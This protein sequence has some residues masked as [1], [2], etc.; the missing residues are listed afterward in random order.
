M[1]IFSLFKAPITNTKPADSWTL[2]QAYRYIKSEDAR[3]QTE[4][5]RAMTEEKQKEEKPRRF[6]SATFSGTFSSRSAEGL[7]TDSGLICIDI[8]H[9]REHGWEPATLKELIAGDGN[10]ATA[11]AFV[12]PRGDGLKAVLV[13]PDGFAHDDYFRT[14][15]RYFHEAYGIDVDPSCRDV[16]R[17]CFLP[18]DAD[19]YFDEDPAAVEPGKLAQWRM[20]FGAPSAGGTRTTTRAEDKTGMAG[21][22]CRCYTVADAIA[23]FLADIYT[24]T[25]R[26]DRY[27]YAKGT[28]FGGVHLIDDQTAY[29]HHATDPAGGRK[30]SAFDLVRI[31]R[32]GNGDDGGPASE[33]FRK[34]KAFALKDPKM[35]AYLAETAKADF[36]GEAEREHN[37]PPVLQSILDGLTGINFRQRAEA[38]GLAPDKKLTHKVE[39]VTAILE[40]LSQAEAQGSGL[41]YSSTGG[42][43][44]YSE[45]Y[46]HEL[47]MKAVEAFLKVACIALGMNFNQ[48]EY[49]EEQAD[50]RKQFEAS[51]LKLEPQRVPGRVLIN[52]RNGTLQIDGDRVQLRALRRGDFIKYQLPYDYD[53]AAACPQFHKYLNRVLPD[54]TSQ[55]VLSEF[56]GNALAPSLRLQ[57]VLIL[58]GSG[59]NG[60]SVFCDIITAVLGRENVTSYSMRSLTNDDSSSRFRL[61]NA[62]LNYSGEGSIKMGSE[63]FKTLAAGEPVEA[64]RKYG[65]SFIMEN[66]AKL[67]F[68]CNL[69]P[70]DIEQSEGFFRRFLIVPFKE[71]ITEAEADPQLAAK[72][73]AAELPGIFNWI[74]EG[75]QRLMKTKK[76]TDC[77]A[78]RIELE[79]YK[80]ESDSVLCFLEDLE[81]K[82]GTNDRDRETLQ[83][84]Y[85]S[86]AYYCNENGHRFRVNRRTFAKR[87]REQGFKDVRAASGTQFYCKMI[88]KPLDY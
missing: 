78:A 45:G 3:R 58:Q 41:A 23:T 81:L 2:A 10:L 22:F 6:P 63:F 39:L 8:D 75:L 59:S 69:L 33:S 60:K 87:M 50:L 73:T 77:E 62:L 53:P 88:K 36:S 57:K 80:K 14:L 35:K 64:R 5:F 68:N 84:L 49:W 47:D 79:N 28:S 4:T 29:S 48:A 25:D 61:A 82:P 46:W 20:D 38:R 67:M 1:T 24:P 16:A 42:Y 74:L 21:A 55:A 56:V 15:Q 54:E 31:H 85:S 44:A 83:D 34:M 66:Y 37:F 26:P 7:L 32:Y 17:A 52:F 12:S 76:F 65:D 72:I 27:T 11:L 43:Y 86:Y 9:A 19:A 30:C 51:A 70:K 71:R 13:R 18:Y 40:I